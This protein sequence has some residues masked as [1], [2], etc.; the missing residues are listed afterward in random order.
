MLPRFGIFMCGAVCL[1]AS[2]ESLRADKKPAPKEKVAKDQL[3]RL[4]EMQATG[5]TLCACLKTRRK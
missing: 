4:G 5:V 3:V 1:F 2:S